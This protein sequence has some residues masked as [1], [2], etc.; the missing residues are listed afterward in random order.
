MKTILAY[1]TPLYQSTYTTKEFSSLIE[2]GINMIPE[3]FR[4]SVKIGFRGGADYE[5]EHICFYYDRP[6]TQDELDLIERRKKEA[7]KHIKETNVY[8]IKQFI[9]KYP[10]EARKIL[11]NIK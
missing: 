5:I 10:E 2:G 4:S 1:S 7:E 9:E 6:Y 11:A 3:E 8:Q